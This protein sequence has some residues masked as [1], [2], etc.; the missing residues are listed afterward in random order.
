MIEQQKIFR[1][2]VPPFGTQVY[3]PGN[4]DATFRSE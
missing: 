1:E 4:P 3:I 2:G